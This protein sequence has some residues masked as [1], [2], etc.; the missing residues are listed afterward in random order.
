MPTAVQFGSYG[1]VDILGVE[2]RHTRGKL[3]L[4]P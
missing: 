3:V 2:M 1:G 4:R